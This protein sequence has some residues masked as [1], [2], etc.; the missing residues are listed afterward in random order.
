[1][2]ET[3][4]ARLRQARESQRLSLQQVSEI[5]KVR[6]H[7]LQALENDD[8]SS[9]PSAA[10]ARGFL[11]LYAEFLGLDMGSLLPPAP[12]P[13]PAAVTPPPVPAAASTPIIARLGFLADLRKRFV[14]GGD[15]KEKSVDASAGAAA[16]SEAPPPAKAA[17]EKKNGL[18]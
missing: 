2:S 7:Y 8:H 1:M 14:R 10:Q 12:V 3:V 13:E 5:T 4:G 9:I 11:R 6:P 18:K 15:K 17:G 16:P